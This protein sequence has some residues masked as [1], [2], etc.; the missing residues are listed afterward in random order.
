MK[1]KTKRIFILLLL[2]FF[3]QNCASNK[4]DISTQNTSKIKTTSKRSFN[5]TKKNT[6]LLDIQ[7]LEI[8]DLNAK[9]AEL[10]IALMAFQQSTLVFTEPLSLYE[11]KIL[12]NNGSVIFGN[13]IYQDDYIVQ[14]ETLIGT[15]SLDK[16]S[17]IRVVDRSITQLEQSDDNMIELNLT[18][19]SN[20]TINDNMSYSQSAK[21]IL[22]GDFI[23]TKDDNNNTILSGQVQNIGAKRADFAKITFT[24]YKDQSQNSS[25][26][27][28]TTF[29]AGSMMEFNQ[30]T[31]S[32]SSLLPSAT[33]TF[34]LV[35]PNDF[36]PFMSY[37]YYIDWEEYE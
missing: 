14:V 23:E 6:E 30:N 34:S 27:E 16:E 22:L 29:V 18:S 21:V 28:Y 13:I 19:D 33:G 15:L 11:K 4:K 8:Q 20:S 7:R 26:K 10:E 12:L 3:I 5:Q 31:T 9:I 17:I 36:G 35:I 32:Y 37:S 24:I 2:P 1:I 25:K